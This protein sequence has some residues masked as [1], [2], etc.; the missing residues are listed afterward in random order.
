MIRPSAMVGA[1]LGM[2]YYSF[3]YFIWKQQPGQSLLTYRTLGGAFFGALVVMS[4]Y[5]PKLWWAGL[6]GG[7]AAGLFVHSLV[8]MNQANTR[9]TPGSVIPVAN[10]LTDEQR[11]RQA[12]KDYIHTLSLQLPIKYDTLQEL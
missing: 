11:K 3:F 9:G 10:L 4:L 5:H 2:S 6:Y 1:A 7:G 8:N 12:N